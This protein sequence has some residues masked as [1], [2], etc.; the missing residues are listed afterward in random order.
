[1][2]SNNAIKDNLKPVNYFKTTNKIKQ[3]F[4]MHILFYNI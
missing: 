1:M 3:L 4:L 2:N